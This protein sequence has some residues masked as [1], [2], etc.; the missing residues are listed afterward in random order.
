VSAAADRSREIADRARMDV[1]EPLDRQLSPLGLR[2]M[3]A[4]APKPGERILDIGCGSGQ[5]VVQLAEA[6]GPGGGVLGVDISTVMLEAAARRAAGFGQVGFIE[7]DAQAFAFEP[8]AFDAIFSRFGVMF[9][10]G[11]V[12]AFA[13]IR[14]ALKP[15]GRLAFVCWRAEAENDLDMTPLRAAAPHLPPQPPEPDGPGPFA[16]ADP[17]TLRRILA[18]AGFEAIEIAAHDQKVGSGNLE[19][20]LTVCLRVGSLG[21]ILRENP[22]LRDAVVAPVRAALA[23]HDGPQ[24]VTLNAATWIVTARVTG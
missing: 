14:R 1:Q 16:F 17:E 9:F 22:E 13:N 3:A 19:A 20:M 11:P 4:L 2:A 23:E 8:G 15:A 18:A 12:A 7:A 5:T 6:V 24:G 10:A 21:K